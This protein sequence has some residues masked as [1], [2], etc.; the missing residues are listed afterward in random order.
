M[1]PDVTSSPND[2][3]SSLH[4]CIAASLSV[5][6]FIHTGVGYVY[7]EALKLVGTGVLSLWFGKKREPNER[8][9]RLTLPV[10]SC[11]CL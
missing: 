1:Q 7:E 10:L 4:R 3:A 8:I 2:A 5:S 9:E 6:L 11:D